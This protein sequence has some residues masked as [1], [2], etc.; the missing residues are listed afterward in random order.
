M[1]KSDDDWMKKFMTYR[2]ECRIPV[3]DREGHGYIV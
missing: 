2:V 1:R 3:E